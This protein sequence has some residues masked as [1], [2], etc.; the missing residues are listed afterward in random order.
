MAAEEGGGDGLLAL[1]FLGGERS[2]FPRVSRGG[3]L[4]A[5]QS[6]TLEVFLSPTGRFCVAEVCVC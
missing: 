6:I 5:P 1:H 4:D 2:T 3:L